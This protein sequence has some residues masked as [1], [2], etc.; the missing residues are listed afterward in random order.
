MVKEGIVEKEVVAVIEYLKYHI[1]GKIPKIKQYST[2]GK[3]AKNYLIC[4]FS[5]H[6]Y[7]IHQLINL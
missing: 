7:K 6:L 5:Y 1:A 4:H 2:Q 3:I